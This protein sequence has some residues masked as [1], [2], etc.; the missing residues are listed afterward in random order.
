VYLVG[1]YGE[2]KFCSPCFFAIIQIYLVKLFAKTYKGLE[3]ILAIELVELGAQDVKTEYRGVQFS[4]DEK[5]LYRSLYECRFALKI[6]KLEHTFEASNEH[7]LYDGVYQYPWRELF[8][9]EKTFAVDA[10]LSNT[11]SSHSK[12]VS[13]KTKDAIADHFNDYYKKRPNVDPKEPDYQIHIHLINN[14]ASIYLDASGASLHQR[15][16]RKHLGLAPLSEVLAAAMVELSGWDMKSP[17]I[18][19]MCGSGTILIEAALKALNYPAQFFR[20]DFGCQKWKD[21]DPKLWE[22]VRTEANEKRLDSINFP[23]EGFDRDSIAVRKCLDNLIA[24]RVYGDV[25]VAHGDFLKLAKPHDQG[26][27]ITNP[28]YDERVK[29]LDSKW[30]YQKMGS[31]LKHD[32]SGYTAWL[33]VPEGPLSKEIGLRPSAKIPLMNGPIP[34]SFQRFD[35]YQGSK[36]KPNVDE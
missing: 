21:F 11:F 8:D 35:L 36:K 26:M 19:P 10:V 17:L 6:L 4:G 13:L 18:D 3:S 20:K 15:G 32:W 30:F 28:P 12:Y 7:Q 9:L 27:I 25:R 22:Q 23:I 1:F 16:Y 5:V 29:V 31:V 34:C 33:L 24:A 2:G 14:K